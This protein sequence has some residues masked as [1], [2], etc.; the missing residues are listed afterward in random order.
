VLDVFEVD[1]PATQG[2][3]RA[4]IAQ[5]GW[6][7][8]ARLRFVAIDFARESLGAALEAAGFRRGVATMFSWLGVTYYLEEAAVRAMLAQLAELA[9][10]GSALVFDYLESA[11]LDPAAMAPSMAK[12]HVAV[13]RAGEPM[14]TG[15]A[16]DEVGALLDAAGWRVVEN[17]G[18]PAIGARWFAGRQDGYSPLP[19]F[20]IAS[21]A[22]K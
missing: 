7:V 9:G 21:A 13:R 11:A 1:H 20:W 8:P 19:H 18:P 4:R 14:R 6:S 22:A 10:P 2:W 17:L 5:L 12:M 16:P 3:K 15:F